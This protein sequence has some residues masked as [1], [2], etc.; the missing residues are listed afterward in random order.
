MCLEINFL[1]IIEYELA[2]FLKVGFL[3]KP[4]TLLPYTLLYTEQVIY[5]YI[6]KVKLHQN[7]K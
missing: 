1:G 7:N 2:G 6:N 5:D 3:A 4:T